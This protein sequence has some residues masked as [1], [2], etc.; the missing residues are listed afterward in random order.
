MYALDAEKRLLHEI[1]S[2]ADC[3]PPVPATA[4]ATTAVRAGGGCPVCLLSADIDTGKHGKC[5]GLPSDYVEG[6]F[7]VRKRSNRESVFLYSI[8]ELVVVWSSSH[9]ELAT[10]CMHFSTIVRIAA[11][12]GCE[13]NERSIFHGDAVWFREPTMYISS[14]LNG[15]QTRSWASLI[16]AWIVLLYRI[17]ASFLLMAVH[18]S[19]VFTLHVELT[20]SSL[21]SPKHTAAGA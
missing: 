1:F 10:Q 17:L 15:R 19:A 4:T 3:S 14:L 12:D 5:M 21:P 6:R 20:R 7:R 16:G 2:R 18:Q 8:M 9:R 13:Q 11:F